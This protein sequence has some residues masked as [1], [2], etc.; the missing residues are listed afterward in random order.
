MEVNEHSPPPSP[1][2]PVT[3]SQFTVATLSDL[4]WSKFVGCLMLEAVERA[5]ARWAWFCYNRLRL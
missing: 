2:N 4:H 5:A 3:G 1:V